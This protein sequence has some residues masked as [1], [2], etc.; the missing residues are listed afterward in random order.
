MFVNVKLLL[1]AVNE[2]AIKEAKLSL[3]SYFTEERFFFYRDVDDESHQIV[4]AP[5]YRLQLQ[6]E[7][8][9]FEII[10]PTFNSYPG[11][12]PIQTFLKDDISKNERNSVATQSSLKKRIEI[13]IASIQISTNTNET[14][15]V[16]PYEGYSFHLNF[17][18]TSGAITDLLVTKEKIPEHS[19]EEPKKEAPGERYYEEDYR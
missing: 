19:L 18:V 2:N 11:T 13:P 10:Y 4:E 16:F 9:F 1:A 8:L 6:D 7:S 14:S 17:V 12:K 3:L 15:F 5:A